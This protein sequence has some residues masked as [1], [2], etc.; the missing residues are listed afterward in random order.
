MATA[1]GAKVVRSAMLMVMSA[2]A[3]HWTGVILA[4]GRSSRM[5]CDKSQLRWHGRTL[6]EHM[7]ALLLEAGAARVVVSGSADGG[8][9]ATHDMVLDRGSRR[10][11]VG[12]L[13]SVAASHV[14]GVLLVV[15]VDMPMLTPAL[16]SALA[17]ADGARC[18]VFASFVLPMRLLL[19]AESRDT[20]AELEAGTGKECSLQNLQARMGGTLRLPV[21]GDAGAFINCNTPDQW[22]L[23]KS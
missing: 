21:A 11:P 8:G 14:D 12:G 10:G 17:D 5:G 2:D 9:E 15:P 20:L 18:S 22:R 7:R 3:G 1:N 19:D 23:L 16:L 4:G 6:L 13:A